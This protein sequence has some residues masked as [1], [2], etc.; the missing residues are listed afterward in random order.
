YALRGYKITKVPMLIHA[1]AFWGFGLLPGYALAY[2]LDMGIYG[3]W[4]ALV[5]SL[6]VAAVLLVW[7]LQWC[8]R[9]QAARKRTV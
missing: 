2:G 8:S 6:T 3:F 7:Y 5:L 9:P 4:T 1:L